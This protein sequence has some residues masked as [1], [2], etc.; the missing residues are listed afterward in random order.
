MMIHYVGKIYNFNP[1][2]PR[3]DVIIDIPFYEQN[4]VSPE[5]LIHLD[6]AEVKNKE[7]S[8]Y[9]N[10]RTIPSTE[11][12]IIK[13]NGLLVTGQQKILEILKNDIHT[14]QELILWNGMP[15]YPQLTYVLG[16]AWNHLLRS[17]ETTSPF[18]EKQ[19]IKITFDYGVNR[20]ISHLIRNQYTYFQ[21][22][23][24]Y[25]NFTNAEILDE[26]IR[27]S[28]Q[29]MKHWF[30]YKIPK[31]ISTINHLQQ[32]VAALNGLEAGD[33]SFY[34]GQ[35]EN[36]FIQPNLVI[37]N[38]YGV[39]RSAIDKLARFI[40]SDWNDEQVLSTVKQ[41]ALEHRDSF[42]DYEVEKILDSL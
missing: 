2:P 16:L 22:L 38:E 5:V 23:S 32:Y 26:A 6:D 20:S 25:Q 18:T 37:L 1:P 12:E 30:G 10:I 13:K 9:Q 11:K 7:S 3:G 21:T 34:A 36:D 15:K 27:F 19:I 14:K 4:P 24:K 8:D 39:P 33:Y 29:A 40:H 17:G 41:S 28:F 31:W 35:I 42:I